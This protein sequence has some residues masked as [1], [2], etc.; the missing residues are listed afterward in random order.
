MDLEFTQLL[1]NLINPPELEKEPEPEPEEP[2]EK[3]STERD[4][5]NREKPKYR[6]KTLD[7]LFIFPNNKNKKKTNYK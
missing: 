4:F 6:K 3:N 7:K 1:N 2:E 5:Y